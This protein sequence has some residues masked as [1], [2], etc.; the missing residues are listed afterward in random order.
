MD[1]RSISK[2]KP[3]L[4]ILQ[5]QNL[6]QDKQIKALANHVNLTMAHVNRY[7]TMLYELDSKLMILNR[8]LQNVMVQLSNIRYE[9]NLIDN[10]QMRINHIYTA[11]YALKEDI[12]ALYK[13][14]SLVYSA[15]ET[16]DYAS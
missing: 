7:E 11:I 2:I 5:D 6:L 12:D 10:M 13:Y 8:T 1:A 9:N 3:N 4:R 16:L 15:T 14:M